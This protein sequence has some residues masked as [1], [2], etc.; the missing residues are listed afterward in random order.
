V[1]VRTADTTVRDLDIDIILRPLLGLEFAPLHVALDGLGIVTEPALKLVIGSR[2]FVRELLYMCFGRDKKVS[3]DKNNARLLGP[4]L[5]YLYSH[6][7][8][9]FPRHGD[10][11][12]E[13]KSRASRAGV[14]WY[15]RPFS[16]R[17]AAEYVTAALTL[18]FTAGVGE[19]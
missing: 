8:K 2:H 9:P 1:K 5:P 7:K 4:H 19:S 3:M 16:L 11:I 13:R 12:I 10:L 17:Q 14:Y 15:G 6:H 18:S